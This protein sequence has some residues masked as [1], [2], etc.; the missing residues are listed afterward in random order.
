MG[1]VTDIAEH[2]AR[3]AEAREHGACQICGLCEQ[4]IHHGHTPVPHTANPCTDDHRTAAERKA[5][6]LDALAVVWEYV[7]RAIYGWTGTGEIERS[8]LEQM[9]DAIQREEVKPDA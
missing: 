9:Y 4:V 7:Q 8:Y 1:S 2:A 3:L 6:A 5:A